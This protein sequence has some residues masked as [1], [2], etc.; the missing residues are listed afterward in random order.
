MSKLL[1]ILIIVVILASLLS[2]CI[3]RGTSSETNAITVEELYST[4]QKYHGQTIIIEGFI[5]LGFET[6]VLSEK[7]KESG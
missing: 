6:M 7:L 3:G 2:G 1:A 5:F 4:P